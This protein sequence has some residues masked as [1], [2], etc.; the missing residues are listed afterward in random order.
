[1]SSTRRGSEGGPFRQER[2]ASAPEFERGL[3]ANLVAKRCAILDRP[4][5][6]QLIWFLQLLSHQAGGIKKVASDLMEKYPERIATTTML[7]FGT[8]PGKIYAAAQVKALRKEFGIESVDLPLYGEVNRDELAAALQILADEKEVAYEVARED[9]ERNPK[10]Y[11][12][13][14]FQKYC[15]KAA[16]DSLEKH[17]LT[18]CLDPAMPL[19]DGQPWYF[20]TLVSTLREYQAEWI[21]ARHPDVVTSIGNALCS[22]LEYS[23]ARRKLVIADGTARIGKTYAAKAWCKLNPGSVRYVELTASSDD[24]SFFREIAASLGV[25]INLNS[26]AQE[27][28]SRIEE[29]LTNGDLMLVI[30]EAHYLWPQKRHYHSAAPT[31]INWIMT[32]LVNRGVAVALITTPQFFRSLM[33]IENTSH[34]TSDQFKGRIG[35]YIK[36]PDTLSRDELEDLAGV[37]LPAGS[38]ESIRVIA[39]YAESSGKYLG[40]MDAIAETAKYFCESDGRQK[41]EF[42]DV[43]RAI[44]ESVTPSDEALRVAL[45]SAI[46]TKRRRVSRA[47]ATPLQTDLGRDAAPLPTERVS[48]RAT[49]P[50]RQTKPESAEV[51]LQ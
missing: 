15:V 25:S 49:L 3:M 28:R 17:L 50:A 35:R 1:M 16:N 26:K 8:K 7:K 24:I 33:A 22:A 20:P 38:A 31:R 9:A 44:R 42:K 19:V 34:W 30:D 48:A 13:T 27:L 10:A 39:R 14:E 21:A 32:A 45:A 43:E 51:L 29:T 4:E 6:R 47:I 40:A 23:A 12:V 46:D 11:P 2:F 41:V 5:D 18:L 36:L 37:L